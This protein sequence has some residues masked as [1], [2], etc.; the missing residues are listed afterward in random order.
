MLQSRKP[1][2]ALQGSREAQDA[3]T[4]HAGDVLGIHLPRRANQQ[5]NNYPALNNFAGFAIRKCYFPSNP[6]MRI[7]KPGAPRKDQKGTFTAQ[8]AAE[9]LYSLETEQPS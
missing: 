1:I 3:S 8:Q 9:F 6:L 5:R 2:K 4:I 7:E